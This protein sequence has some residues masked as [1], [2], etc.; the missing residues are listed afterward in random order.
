MPYETS[1][2]GAPQ[3][4][5]QTTT[6]VKLPRCPK[7]SAVYCPF[8][9]IHFRRVTTATTCDLSWQPLVGQ[10][11]AA[12]LELSVQRGTRVEQ[13]LLHGR[14][15]HERARWGHGRV[16]AQVA[17]D[18]GHAVLRVAQ[19]RD[20]QRQGGVEARLGGGDVA[21]LGEPTALNLRGEQ[22][23]VDGAGVA[24]VVVRVAAYHPLRPHLNRKPTKNGWVTMVT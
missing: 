16:R 3:T 21:R 20:Q 10:L 11:Q 9:H 7:P 18:L 6:Y 1:S 4:A 23:A 5:I 12:P 8:F 22:R 2:S 24:V 17:L 15:V 19:V 14:L 13:R